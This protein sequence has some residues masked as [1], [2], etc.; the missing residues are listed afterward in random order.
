MALIP[1]TGGVFT[2]DLTHS[3]PLRATEESPAVGSERSGMSTTRLWDR[4]V[5][6]GFPGEYDR[7]A[8]HFEKALQHPSLFF[9]PS[10]SPITRKSFLEICVIIACHLTIFASSQNYSIPPKSLFAYLF[11]LFFDSFSPPLPSGQ[12]SLP[13]PPHLIRCK[14]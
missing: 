8:H 1:A 4:K 7:S 6:G 9:S 3:S 5:H 14:K 13:L 12:L 10:I 11:L 2:V